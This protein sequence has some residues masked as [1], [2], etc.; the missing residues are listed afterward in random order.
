MI[1][2]EPAPGGVEQL[3]ESE[4][5]ALLAETN[6]EFAEIQQ[7]IIVAKF[8]AENKPA[9]EMVERILELI[10]L[11]SDL[12]AKKELEENVMDLA[13]KYLFLAKSIKNF[14]DK[15]IPSFPM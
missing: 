10:K 3:S 15:K 7:E 4:L 14:T 1:Q 5:V 8:S 6:N 11:L 9:E 13:A 12:A 2:I